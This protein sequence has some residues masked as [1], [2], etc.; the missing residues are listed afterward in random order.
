MIQGHVGQVMRTVI[1]I[2]ENTIGNRWEDKGS[3]EWKGKR[4][5]SDRKSYNRRKKWRTLEMRE[6]D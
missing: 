5:I 3:E 6:R 2:E 1:E 4:I